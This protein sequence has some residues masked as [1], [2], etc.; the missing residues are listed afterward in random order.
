MGH[1]CVCGGVCGSPVL[2]QRCVCR[3]VCV[4]CVRAE[5]CVRHLCVCRGVHGSLMCMR[6][7]LPVCVRRCVCVTCVRAEVCLQVRTLEVGLLAAGEGTDVIPSAGEVR[8]WGAT[9]CGQKHW[10][11]GEGEELGVAQGDDG[12]R[13]LGGL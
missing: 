3:C 10:G 8:L 13:G 1:L 4:T 5:V 12:L 9:S 7:V 2:V 11:G 6:S